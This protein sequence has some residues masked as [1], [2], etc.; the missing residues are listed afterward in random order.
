[1]FSGADFMRFGCEMEIENGGKKNPRFVE[2]AR[3]QVLEGQW[4]A[5]LAAH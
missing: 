1:M 4:L 5:T 2:V 3:S